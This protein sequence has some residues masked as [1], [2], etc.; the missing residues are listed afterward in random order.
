MSSLFD[1]IKESVEIRRYNVVSGS[2]D[3][4]A[5]TDTSPA[6]MY[7]ELYQ[8]RTLTG[9]RAEIQNTGQTFEH[10]S[11]IAILMDPVSE[12]TEGDIIYRSQGRDPEVLNVTSA[13]PPVLGVQQITLAEKGK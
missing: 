9:Q 8:G 1:N 7:I 4:I 10:G 5:N 6:E 2:E 13:P 12:L 11:Y 3:V